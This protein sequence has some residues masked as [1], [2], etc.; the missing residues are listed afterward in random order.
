MRNVNL[1]IDT[2]C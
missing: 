2:L 1:R